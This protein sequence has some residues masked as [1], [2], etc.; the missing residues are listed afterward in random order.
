MTALT[1]NSPLGGQTAFRIGIFPPKQHLK[2]GGETTPPTPNPVA[3]TDQMNPYTLTL[4][5]LAA[6]SLPGFGQAPQPS[7]PATDQRGATISPAGAYDLYKERVA[8]GGNPTLIIKNGQAQLT[9]QTTALNPGLVTGGSAPGFST[10]ALPIGVGTYAPAPS[11]LAIAT[12][13]ITALEEQVKALKDLN[14][15]LEKA[16]AD[17]TGNQ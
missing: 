12:Q 7:V 13:K 10:I 16:L 17:C 4:I 9:E 11:Q 8:E 6:T 2:F 15:A 5:A 1:T 3:A 14:V